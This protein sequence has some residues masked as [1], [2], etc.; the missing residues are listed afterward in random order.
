MK[1]VNPFPLLRAI[2]GIIFLVSGFEKLIVPYQNF[3]YVIENY[4]IVN[5]SLAIITSRLMP[6]LELLMGVF[7]IL[8]LWTKMALSG[9]IALFST[10]LIVVGQAMIRQLP[11]T[12]CGC[13]GEFISFPLHVIFIFDLISLCITC[14]LLIKMDDTNRFSLDQYFSKIR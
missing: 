11:I 3:L 14:L 9:A 5:D 8:G 4:K 6:W 10:F 12:E 13:F 7:L 1:K 2:I